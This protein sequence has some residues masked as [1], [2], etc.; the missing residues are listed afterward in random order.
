MKNSERNGVIGA[1][2]F[3]YKNVIA[4]LMEHIKDVKDNELKIIVDKETANKS[5]VSIQ[6]ILTHVVLCGYNYVTMIDIH[7]GNENSSWPSKENLN[8]AEEYCK[9]LE[10]M[11]DFTVEYFEN[12]SE[13]E[14]AEFSAD[15]KLVTFWGQLYDYEQLMEHAIVHVSRHRR[16]IVNFKNKLRKDNGEK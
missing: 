8:S 4:D 7:R 1:L 14:M 11:Y 6:S 16:Q 15:K 13:S 5:C 2:L 9:A 3:E 12:V 10:K